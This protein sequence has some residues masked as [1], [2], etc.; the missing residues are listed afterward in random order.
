[1][2]AILNFLAVLDIFGT[3]FNFR[4]KDKEKYQT[5]FGGFILILF[6][7]LALGMGIYYFIPFINRKNYTIVYYT[8]N[9]AETE[10]VDLFASQSNLAIGFECDG[11][12]NEKR[13]IYELFNIRARLVIFEKNREGKYIKDKLDIT[14]HK[15]TYADFYNKFDVQFDYLEGT[16]FECI[17]EENKNTKI[18]G[19]YADRIF[20]YFEF[21]VMAKNKSKELTDEVE[22]FLFN[23]DCR[24]QMVYTDIIIDLD[25]YKNPITQYLNEIFIQLNPALYI[26]RNVFFMNQAFTND[27]FLMF[28]FGDDQEPEVKPLYSRY[29]E[30]SLYKGLNRYTN[31][32]PE[33]EYYSR[34]YIRADTKKT[35]IKRKYQKFMEFYADASSLLIAIYEIVGIILAYFY[36]FYGYHSLNKML[37]F[38]KDL[39]NPEGFNISKK[40][41]EIREL[42]SITEIKQNIS[43]NNNNNKIEVQPKGSKNI[44]NFPPKKRETE[45]QEVLESGEDSKQKDVQIYNN[46]RSKPNGSKGTKTSSHLK[47]GNSKEKKNY[48]DNSIPSQYDDKHDEDFKGDYEENYQKYKVNHMNRIE[49]SRG[50]VNFKYNDNND[51]YFSE[52]IGTSIEDYSSDY[53]APKRSKKK[54]KVENSFNVLEVIIT[55][56]FKCC[57]C[58]DMNIKNEAN[59]KANELLFKKMDIITHVR[60]QLLFDVVNQTMIDS[61]KK[62]L[63]NF[64]GRPI[65]NINNKGKRKG[66]FDEFYKTYSE[67]EFNKYLNKVQEI[68][69]KTEKDERET[70]LL[71][72]SNEHMKGF[73]Q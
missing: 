55:Q 5:A 36:T 70:K 61:N 26:K 67:K 37:F 54:P 29:E 4:Y 17:P 42:I 32:P 6:I 62:T 28:V 48:K 14:T 3:F 59:E 60:N 12:E 31:D 56:L 7:A 13:D 52:S 65:I 25:N 35:V 71:S 72:I 44:K 58:R 50:R 41:D 9:L 57:I 64:L 1:M 18:Q 19:I 47:Q 69:E 30:Y 24:V 51:G 45:R 15:C 66:E 20:T 27:D 39:E 21:S 2:S 38:F 46:S 16:K 11:N 8:M 40:S 49:N 23:N 53:Y 43:D 68:V 10:A 22:R 73:T 63:I 33:Y 34:I